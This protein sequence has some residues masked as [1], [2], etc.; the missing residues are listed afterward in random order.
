VADERDIET[1]DVR[2]ESYGASEEYTV[3]A[4][5][6]Y[7]GTYRGRFHD[8]VDRAEVAALQAAL[9]RDATRDIGT[10]AAEAA[11][12]ARPIVDRLGHQLFGELFSGELAGGLRDTMTLAQRDGRPL[13]IRLRLES[14]PELGPLPWELLRDDE[15][16]R[17]VALTAQ[18]QVVRHLGRPEPVRD[19]A[20]E[21]PL[22]VLV[23]VSSPRD[24]PPLAVEREWQAL[25]T[26]LAPLVGDGRLEVRRVEPPTI[27]QLGR[28]LLNGPWHVLH[29]IGHGEQTTSSLAFCDAGGGAN[30]VSAETL[31]VTLADAVELRLVVLNACHSARASER[32]AFGGVAQE[33]LER[34]VPAVVAMQFAIS[35]A[36][37]IAFAGRFYAAVSHG[38]AVDRAV[39]EARRL[40]FER[41][42]EWATP[43]VHLRGDGVL[44]DLTRRLPAV[45]AARRRRR[46][47]PLAVT[48]IAVVA[49]LAASVVW[50]VTRR[51]DGGD[52]DS[53][54]DLEPPCPVVDAGWT[55]LPVRADPTA[56]LPYNGETMEI[57]VRSLAYRRLGTDWQLVATAALTNATTGDA[58][59]GDYWVDT[60]VV[61]GR[62]F[63]QTC[64]ETTSQVLDPG[65]VA[66]VR[67]GYTSR[68]EPTGLIQLVAGDSTKTNV[69]ITPDTEYSDC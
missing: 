22:R 20:V 8:R 31:A 51:G 4:D 16:G 39:G 40:L 18:T 23:V 36:A 63:E 55:Q 61:A 21:G 41:G 34:S 11:G 32:D 59:I 29:F 60:L 56:S 26:E 33:L 69:P 7:G 9:Q 10:D 2:I 13:R 66:D 43:V 38:W 42:S 35:D 67:T 27:E 58:T 62:P 44:F 1:F 52:D 3:V 65:F 5:S 57:K 68:C 45:P 14:V 19:V 28:E 48:A 6:S 46:R 64:F 50:L 17:F 15:R 53:S 47:G 30:F 37:A 24:L 25:Q 54:D 12:D 49:L